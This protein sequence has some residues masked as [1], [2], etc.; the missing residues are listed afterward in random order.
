MS[1]SIIAVEQVGAKIKPT[2]HRLTRLL[3]LARPYWWQFAIIM[4]VTFL[5][6]FLTITYPALLGQ[7]IDSVISKNA[8]T[9]HTIVFLLIGLAAAQACISF[10]Q[11]YWMTSI[12]EKIVIDL[13]T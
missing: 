3:S 1:E 4:L 10:L 6:S 2:R 12:G 9:L 7:I 11:S 8:S 5:S 13:R